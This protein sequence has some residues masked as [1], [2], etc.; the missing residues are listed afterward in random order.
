MNRILTII[1]FV[2][3]YIILYKL[4]EKFKL[5][6]KLSKTF[7]IPSKWIPFTFIC[8]L[9]II[10]LLFNIL[11]L[12]TTLLKFIELIIITLILTSLKYLYK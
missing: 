7:K 6:N 10:F 1:L 9:I 11:N 8:V 5:I 3:V 2:I 4:D 12:N